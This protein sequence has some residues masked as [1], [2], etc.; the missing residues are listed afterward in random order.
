LNRIIGVTLS[1]AE[2]GLPILRIKEP[3]KP[4]DISEIV[5]LPPLFDLDGN[6]NDHKAL[7]LSI[8]T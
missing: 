7:I 1:S 3:P 2:Y 8:L 5:D 6:S 4:Y